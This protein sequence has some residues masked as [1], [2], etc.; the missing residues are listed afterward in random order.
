[1]TTLHIAPGD[2]AG[3]ALREAIRE[4]GRNED[5]LAFRDDLSCGPI[6]SNDPAAR[7][8]W[9]SSFGYDAAE[10]ERSVRQFWDRLTTTTDRLVVWFARH[11]ARELSFFHAT[12]ERL[13]GR[14]YEIVDVTGLELPFTRLDGSP[15]LTGP[16]QAVGSMS[17]A[18]LK[19][20]FASGRPIAEE[21]AAR[22]S[23]RWRDLK[24]ENAHFRIVTAAG[25]ASAPD[26][27]FDPL[28]LE[29]ATDQWKKVLRIIG[30]TMGY[31]SEPYLQVGDVMLLARIENLIKQGKLVADGE[32]SDPRNC[33]IR[34][35]G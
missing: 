2:S 30:E 22:Y 5:V 25:L 4:A 1:M 11:A 14:H 27:Y 9:W 32:I 6:D 3:G 10:F 26:D 19:D 8:D 13:E 15:A 24:A 16:T 23:A 20:L 18:N 12:A 28:I 35:P 17:V 34:L 33:C 29:R 21:E 31:N 7:A